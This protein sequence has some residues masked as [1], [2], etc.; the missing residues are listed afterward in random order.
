MSRR[1]RKGGLGALTHTDSKLKVG[2]LT[3]FKIQ[4]S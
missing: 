4:P 1:S 3:K 2:D